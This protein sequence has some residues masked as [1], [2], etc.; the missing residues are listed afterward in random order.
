MRTGPRDDRDGAQ[1]SGERTSR[2]GALPGDC[3]CAAP[4]TFAP[5]T[6]NTAQAHAINAAR[7][8]SRPPTSLVERYRRGL[9]LADARDIDPE[10]ET[11]ARLRR[12][13]ES[14]RQLDRP[15]D[16][17]G[18]GAVL[19]LDGG[20]L[21]FSKPVHE[22]GWAPDADLDS[23]TA[24]GRL[25]VAALGPDQPAQRGTVSRLDRDRRLFVPDAVRR[26]LGIRE[27]DELHVVIDRRRQLVILESTRRVIARA[28]P[29]LYGGTDDATD[30]V[31]S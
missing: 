26:A 30:A 29:E 10:R 21:P 3:R 24:Q 2:S 15:V 13:A 7:T 9:A 18:R 14:R 12:S 8:R 23:W 17:D 28:Y 16:L 27:R 4:G 31:A 22:L 19:R 20:R 5:M 6:T 11:L 1:V 25:F